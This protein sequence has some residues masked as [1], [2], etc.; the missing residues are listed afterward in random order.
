MDAKLVELNL[1]VE[2]PSSQVIKRNGVW[3]E[4][5][6]IIVTTSAF[7]LDLEWKDQDK[8][9]DMQK[10]ITHSRGTDKIWNLLGL[11]DWALV[12]AEFKSNAHTETITYYHMVEGWELGK[13]ICQV[14]SKIWKQAL[15]VI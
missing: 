15:F 8:E 7:S 13:K 6:E 14:P 9:V 3:S 12:D 10:L 5:T 4:H 2:T 1:N 11:D